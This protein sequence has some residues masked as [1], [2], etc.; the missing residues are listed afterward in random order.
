MKEKIQS[1]KTP[2][3]FMDTRARSLL[4]KHKLSVLELP[5]LGQR[6]YGRGKIRIS[7]LTAEK[8]SIINELIAKTILYF[9]LTKR[10]R[11]LIPYYGNFFIDPSD[12]E[13]TYLSFF[14]YKREG[15]IESYERI[16]RELLEYA[17]RLDRCGIN[18][19]FRPFLQRL[20]KIPYEL[21]HSMFHKCENTPKPVLS[22]T[23]GHE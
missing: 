7:L 9:E 21:I 1:L 2:E 11:F 16:G 3:S 12:G 13:K 4:L 14:H 22:T 19:Y 18:Y 10:N 23:E 17:T 5:D 15:S 6:L 8:S 20:P